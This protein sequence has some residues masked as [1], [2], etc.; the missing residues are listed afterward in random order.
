[1][2]KTVQNAKKKKNKVHTFH[3]VEKT[4]YHILRL[5]LLNCCKKKFSNTEN[6]HVS[7]LIGGCFIGG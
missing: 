4:E 7:L 6:L 3:R 2:S 5:N 1:M